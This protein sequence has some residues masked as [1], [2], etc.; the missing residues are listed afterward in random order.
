MNA[1]PTFPSISPKTTPGNLILFQLKFSDLAKYL[2]GIF[3][4]EVKEV[5]IIDSAFKK[6]VI[7]FKT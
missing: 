6:V 7:S 3:V 1:S 5:E 2:T 4:P